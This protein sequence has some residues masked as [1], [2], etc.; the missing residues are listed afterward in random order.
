[1]AI[2]NTFRIVRLIQCEWQSVNEGKLLW[3]PFNGL[4]NALDEEMIF[5][6]SF[7]CRFLCVY[8]YLS[9]STRVSLSLFD[10]SFVCFIV[11]I[12]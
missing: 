5:F 1:M 6:L 11:W 4:R 2:E 10:D 3:L 9:L 7:P 12:L 8:S